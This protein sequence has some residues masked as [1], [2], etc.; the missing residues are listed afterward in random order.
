[1][2]LKYSENI[3]AKMFYFCVLRTKARVLFFPFACQSRW[4]LGTFFTPSFLDP[5][6]S[7]WN[8]NSSCPK[9]LI[10][11]SVTSFLTSPEPKQ[12]FLSFQNGW[13]PEQ[14]G[15]ASVQGADPALSQVQVAGFYLYRFLGHRDIG[16]RHLGYRA[17]ESKSTVLGIDITAWDER[18]SVRWPREVPHTDRCQQAFQGHC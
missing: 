3:S 1:M 8:F 10:S 13:R 11:Q 17:W 12:G 7:L 6:S 18:W 2:D 4:D 15:P 5:T 16:T 9:L 14:W